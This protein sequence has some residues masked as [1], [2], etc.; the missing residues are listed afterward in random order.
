MIGEMSDGLLAALAGG[1]GGMVLGLAARL[2]RFCSLG[3]IE[4]ALYGTS[5]TRLRMWPL[6]IAVAV[7]AMAA[8]TGAGWIDPAETMYLRFGWNPLASVIGGLVFGYGMALAGSCGFGA[9]ARLGGGDIR[10]LVIV[11]VIGISA[12]AAVSGPLALPRTLVF[13]VEPLAEGAMPPGLGHWLGG[14]LGVA[15]WQ[16]ALVLA[17][18]LGWLSLSDPGFRRERAAVFWSVAVG[19]AV[20]GGFLATAIVARTGFDPVAVES[21]SFTVPPGETILYLM[22]SS[23]GG[24]GFPIGSVLGV[25]AGAALGAALKGQFRWEAC[26][27]ARELGRQLGGAALMGVGGVV[28]F[29]CTIGQG[30]SAFSV[31]AAGAPVT[32]AAIAAGAALGLKQLI[33]GF[34]VS[35]R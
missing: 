5:G 1:A 12:F 9:L 20:A 8:M 33:G 19:L 26:D 3:A 27:D 13:P 18:P 32:L 2:G 35:R 31:L 25:V 15:P 6:A 7:A 30:L 23:A 10:A 28:A 14:A 4:E 29:G 34:T 16:A 21:H 22:T 11:A 17:L 24:I